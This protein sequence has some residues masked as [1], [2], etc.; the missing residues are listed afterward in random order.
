MPIG[1]SSINVEA[2][3]AIDCGGDDT[4]P[5][6]RLADLEG[7]DPPFTRAEDERLQAE[8]DGFES[9]AVEQRRGVKGAEPDRPPLRELAE[10]FVARVV[11]EDPD[12]FIADED[13]VE[14][15]DNWAKHDLAGNTRGTLLR[16]LRGVLPQFFP[17]AVYSTAFREPGKYERPDLPAARRGISG[18]AFRAMGEGNATST[19]VP[20][21]GQVRLAWLVASV[22]KCIEEAQSLTDCNFRPPRECVSIPR[23]DFD[24]LRAA[25]DAVVAEA[26][27]PAR[28][29]QDDE[30]LARLVIGR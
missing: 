13:L 20:D 12:G 5:L 19:A 3:P 9:E 23:V 4:T 21:A 14:A 7:E 29:E 2:I 24:R 1:D 11:V 26:E 15:F 6:E 10:E 27:V 16:A 28:T 8:A 30:A 25:L 22:T 18:I 17:R